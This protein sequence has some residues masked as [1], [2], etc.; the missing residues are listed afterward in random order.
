MLWNRCAPY[1]VSAPCPDERAAAQPHR[2]EVLRK[3]RGFDGF[4]KIDEAI[5]ARRS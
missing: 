4:F 1:P 2:V 3:R 5:P